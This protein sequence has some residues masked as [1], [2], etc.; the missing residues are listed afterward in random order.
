[1]KICVY[2]QVYSFD[3]TFTLSTTPEASIACRNNPENRMMYVA[4]PTL[5]F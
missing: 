3:E 4:A 2:I 5:E 1:M